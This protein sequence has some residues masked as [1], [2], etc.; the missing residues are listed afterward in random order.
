MLLLMTAMMLLIILDLLALR[1]G[2]E[3]REGFSGL[4]RVPPRTAANM[5]IDE[6]LAAQLRAGRPRRTPLG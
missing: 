2:A 4:E 5:M 3:S 1:Y 6:A